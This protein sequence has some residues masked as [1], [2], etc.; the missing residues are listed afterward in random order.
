M[1][2]S[3]RLRHYLKTLDLAGK[4]CEQKNSSSSQKSLNYGCKKFYRIGPSMVAY[5]DRSFDQFVAEISLGLEFQL[6]GAD[7]VHAFL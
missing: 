1:L 2:H 4:A 3:D 6:L 7:P 5:K